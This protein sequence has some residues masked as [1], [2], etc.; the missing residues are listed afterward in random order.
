[1]V[2]KLLANKVDNEA[3]DSLEG[4]VGFNG[5][6]AADETNLQLTGDLLGRVSHRDLVTIHLLIK[7]EIIERYDRKALG[8]DLSLISV[9]QFRSV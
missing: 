8:A 6:R 7:S 3:L 2:W 5:D 9:F 4:K 1:M